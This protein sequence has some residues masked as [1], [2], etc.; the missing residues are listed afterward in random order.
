[1]VAFALLSTLLGALTPTFLSLKATSSQKAARSLHALHQ[2]GSPS[3]GSR[4]RLGFLMSW[5]L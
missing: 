1:M 3:S 4:G 2:V 5:R